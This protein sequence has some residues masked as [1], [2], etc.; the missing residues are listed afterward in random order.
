MALTKW[1]DYQANSPVKAQQ[2]TQTLLCVKGVGV[3]ENYVLEADPTAGGLPVVASSGP[4]QYQFNGTSTVVTED[5]SNSSN[6]RPL[7]V[8]IETAV[9]MTPDGFA[10]LDYTVTPVTTGAYVQISAGLGS[11]ANRIQI[12]DSSGQTLKL[13]F[14]PPGSEADQFFIFPGGVEIPVQIPAVVRLSIKAV[15]A[16]ATVG[17]ISVNFLT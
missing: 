12:F 7:P 13:A 10:R 4:I 2:L 16:N 1:S 8:K 11:P 17:E 3:N 9:G 5:T 14:G 15:S 6:N